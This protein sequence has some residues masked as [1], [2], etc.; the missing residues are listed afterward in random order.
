MKVLILL[1]VY[2]ARK[3]NFRVQFILFL[4]ILL[5]V[6]LTFH[7]HCLIFRTDT[8]RFCPFLLLFFH[9]IY[10]AVRTTPLENIWMHLNLLRVLY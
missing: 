2:E 1:R 9:L 6:W 4:V 10:P 3:L 8:F 7:R 5:I